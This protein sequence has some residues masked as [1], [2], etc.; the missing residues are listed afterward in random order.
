MIS[1]ILKAKKASCR[2]ASSGGTVLLTGKQTL[3]KISQNK[4]T[5]F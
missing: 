5:G 4:K 1:G 2:D 3:K